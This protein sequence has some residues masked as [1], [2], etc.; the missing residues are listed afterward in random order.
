ML[1]AGILTVVLAPSDRVSF[2][3]F[4]HQSTERIS[5]VENVDPIQTTACLSRVSSA[6]HIATYTTIWSRSSW[7]LD[8]IVAI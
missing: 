7:E 5:P 2:I 4:R 6:R 8:H 3:Y 1:D